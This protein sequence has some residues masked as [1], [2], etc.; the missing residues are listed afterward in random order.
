MP[1]STSV[2]LTLNNVVLSDMCMRT[3]IMELDVTATHAHL[4]GLN[5]YKLEDHRFRASATFLSS[6]IPFTYNERNISET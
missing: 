6:G 3:Q 2:L 4:A 1:I 5:R